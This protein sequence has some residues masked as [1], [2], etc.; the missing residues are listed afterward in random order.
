MEIDVYQNR[1]MRS[2]NGGTRRENLLCRA[3]GIAG[4]AGEVVDLVK[5]HV[6][7]GH[8]EDR[9]QLAEELGDVLWYVAVLA[10]SQGLSLRQVALLNLE[11]LEKRYPGGFT[12][13]DSRWRKEA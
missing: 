8:P 2:A 5:K 10:A 4:E 7:H 12:E 1:A 6:Y 13:A 11:K 3:L 9:G